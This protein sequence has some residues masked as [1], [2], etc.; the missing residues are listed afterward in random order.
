M[1]QITTQIKQLFENDNDQLVAFNDRQSFSRRDFQKHVSQAVANLEQLSHQKYLLFADNTYDFAVNFMALIIAG[2]DIV[3]TANTKPDWLNSIRQSYQAVISDSSHADSLSITHYLNSVAPTDRLDIRNNLLNIHSQSKIQF[4]T[5]G[6]SSQPKAVSKQFS[7]LL[8]E[9]H[10]LEQ[11]FGAAI[12]NSIVFATVSHHHIY[13]LIFRLL[14]PLFYKKPFNTNILLYPEELVAASQRYSD[15]CLI[16]SPAFLSRHDKQLTDMALTQCFSSGSLLSPKAAHLTRQQFNLYPV[17]VFGSTETGGIGY[18]TQANNNTVWSLFPSVA[19]TLN[20][21]GRA[22]LTSPYIQNPEYLDDNIEIIGESQFR[23]HGRTDRV[24]KIEE[25]RVSLD[26]LEQAIK[27]SSLVDECKVV[28]I[29]QH[30]TFIGAVVELSD[31][32]SDFLKNH[33]KLQLNQQLKEMLDSKF[34][35]VAI[36]RKWRYFDHLPYNS[37]GKLPINTLV[38]LF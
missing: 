11:L 17:E 4:Y 18:R 28:V 25:K 8:L 24:V 27:E 20:K 15:I 26:A 23:L 30:R 2:K 21:E 1:D 3:L 12:R 10:N 19:L 9:A 6:S 35:A 37:Q 33:S 31:S 38:T 36:P 16:S 34:E 5:S 7:Q 14:W 13:G 32:G 29:Q 22:R